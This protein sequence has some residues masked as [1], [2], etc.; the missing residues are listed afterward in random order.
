[1]I[2]FIGKSTNRNRMDTIVETACKDHRSSS[3][4]DIACVSKELEGITC[5][6][7]PCTSKCLNQ[8]SK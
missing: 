1:M 3:V 5:F 6:I 4:G 2:I 8:A 7:L